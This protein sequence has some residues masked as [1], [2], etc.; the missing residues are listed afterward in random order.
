MHHNSD[1]AL[2]RPRN[3]ISF[4]TNTVSSPVPRKLEAHHKKYILINTR[5]TL[6]SI[7]NPLNHPH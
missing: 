7:E 2:V 3:S 6:E 5:T 1:V 4:H